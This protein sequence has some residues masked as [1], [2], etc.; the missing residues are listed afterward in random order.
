MTYTPFDPTLLTSLDLMKV[1]RRIGDLIENEGPLPDGSNFADEDID[2]YLSSYSGQTDPDKYAAA[3]ILENMATAWS[4]I[5]DNK[6]GPMSESAS[7]VAKGL[8]EQAAVLRSGGGG[9]QAGGIRRADGYS[10][11][12]HPYKGDKDDNDDYA[13]PWEA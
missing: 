10:S 4:L 8:R 2:W 11:N 5:P 9:L 1:R 12:A 7:Q 6:Q 13:N 3:D